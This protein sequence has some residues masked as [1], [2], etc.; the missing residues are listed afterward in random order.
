M[1]YHVVTPAQWAAQTEATEYLADSLASEGFIHCSTATQVRG[2][3]ER[4]YVAEPEVLMLHLDEALLT[5]P[6]RY[7]ISTNQEAFPHL[8]GSINKAAIV[9]ITTVK[10]GGEI[11][12]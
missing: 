11:L 3:L 7:E 4:Y 5:A 9:Q 8:F 6:L 10:Q 12:P 2:V 1:I